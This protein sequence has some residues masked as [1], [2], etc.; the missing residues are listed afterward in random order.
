M[1]AGADKFDKE[2]AYNIRHNY[3]MAYLWEAVVHVAVSVA[4]LTVSVG[5][6]ERRGSAQTTR[7]TTAPRL[8]PLCPLVCMMRVCVRVCVVRVVVA[9]EPRTPLIARCLCVVILCLFVY[10]QRPVGSSWMSISS[11]RSRSRR[12]RHE[13]AGLLVGV[14]VR[15]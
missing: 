14:C 4:L 13:K 7:R 11:F 3:G 5:I 9:L 10:V 6:Q 12:R 8:S 15:A 1:S 2:Y